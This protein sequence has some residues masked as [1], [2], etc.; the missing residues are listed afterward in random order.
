MSAEPQTS[1]RPALRALLDMARAGNLPSVASN[2]IAALL[3]S[4]GG[5]AWPSAGLLGQA[6]LAGF[7]LYA[8]GAT[9]NDV[10]DADFDRKHRPE[11]AIPTGVFSRNAAL[12]IGAIEMA[13]GVAILAR[14]GA[15]LW[16][17]AVLVAVILGYDWLHKRWT[18]SVFLMAGCRSAL[19]LSLATLPGQAAG[20]LFWTWTAAVFAYIV[21]LSLLAR[22]EYKQGGGEAARTGRRIGRLLAF[23]PLI[24]AITLAVAGAWAG[25]VV[26]VVAIPVGRLAQRLAAST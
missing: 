20:P 24:D 8:G 5:A 23:I 26:C 3:L 2:V 21:V 19:G 17:L 15:A 9:L 14:A 18:G 7:L 13:L 16:A 6:L 10:A 11:R 4:G 12:A 25:A 22:M 1:R